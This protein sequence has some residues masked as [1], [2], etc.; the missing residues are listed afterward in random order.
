[1]R[2]HY[3]KNFHEIFQ[4]S[5]NM[6]STL[7]KSERRYNDLFESLK[8]ALKKRSLK[9]KSDAVFTSDFETLIPETLNKHF[10]AIETKGCYFHFSQC[11]IRRVKK[12]GLFYQL[13]TLTKIVVNNL[14]VHSP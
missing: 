11:I 13:S 2:L 3:I 9:L 8:Y 5:L 6:N 10:P 12:S 1:M 7:D 4:I 14:M